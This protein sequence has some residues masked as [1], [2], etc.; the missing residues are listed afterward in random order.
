LELT[1]ACNAFL[2]AEQNSLAT[3]YQNPHGPQNKPQFPLEQTK[4]KIQLEQTKPKIQLEQTKP[5]FPLEQTKPKSPLEPNKTKI[6]DGNK[7]IQNQ[8][9]KKQYGRKETSEVK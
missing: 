5:K 4:P 2:E 7:T 1:D 6:T 3:T 9:K 8:N